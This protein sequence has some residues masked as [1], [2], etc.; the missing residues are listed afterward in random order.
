MRAARA[1]VTGLMAAGLTAA[2]MASTGAQ[3]PTPPAPSAA[4]AAKPAAKPTPRRPAPPAETAPTA[5]A[6]PA[7]AAARGEP[8][9]A[10]GAFQRG[11]YLDRL[12]H[13]DP[14]RRGEG[15]RQG[16]DAAGRA[17]RQWLRRQP[18][19]QEGGR[20]VP[21]RRR[22]RRPRGDVRARRCST[23]PAAAAPSTARRP[24]SCSPTAAKLG[25]HRRRLRSRPALSRRPDVPAGLRARRRAVPQRRGSRQSGSAIRARRRSTRKAAASRRT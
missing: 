3:A 4:P 15:R 16:D 13:R 10:F 22:P 17:L 19:R 14:P 21:A 1:V 6:V 20:M 9:L 7:P 18:R 8:D 12:R 25:Q 5:A 24:P 23:S 2:W 11:F